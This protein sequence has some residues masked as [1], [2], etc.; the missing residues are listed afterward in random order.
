MSHPPT[1]LNAAGQPPEESEPL[2]DW[3]KFVLGMAIA[4]LVSYF[5][6]QV[7]TAVAIGRLEERQ[8]NQYQELKASIQLMREDLRS[9]MQRLQ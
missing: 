6:S 2:P 4:A 5:T 8:N 3:L 7:N 1:I 9:Y